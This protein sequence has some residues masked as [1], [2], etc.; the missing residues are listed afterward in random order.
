MKKLTIKCD[1]CDKEFERAEKEI[2]RSLKMGRKQFCSRHCCGVAVNTFETLKA[3][4]PDRI[5]LTAWKHIKKRR[6]VDERSPFKYFLK[7]LKNTGRKQCVG[8]DVDYLFKLWQEQ[9]GICPF[10]GWKLLLPYGSK[11]WGHTE[12]R[13]HRAS[14]DRIDNSKDYVSGNIRFISVMANYARNTMTDDD[15]IEFCRAV[16][17]HQA[18]KAIAKRWA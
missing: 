3:R 7:S 16:A 13:N 6:T 18:S 11:G 15:L 12:N 14:I 4:M 2:N 9:G 10:T 5:R 1:N 8:I 17:N